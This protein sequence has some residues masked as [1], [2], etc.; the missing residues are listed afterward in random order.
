VTRPLD[1]LGAR[2]RHARKKRQLGQEDLAGAANES[3][4]TISKIERG[5]IQQPTSIARLA[6][7][8]EVWLELGH[9]DEPDWDKSQHTSAGRVA[10][11]VAQYVI[12]SK[13]EDAPHIDLGANM[14]PQSL[15]RVFWTP[16][17]DDA[18]APR[19]LAGKLL[20]FDKGMQPRAGDGI[21]VSDASGRLSVRLYRVAPLGRWTA[22][23]LNPSYEPM[24]SEQH[25]LAVVAVLKAEEGRWA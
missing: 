5:E 13:F 2:L 8:L 23:A 24:D 18:M 19:V 16:M 6:A 17:P 3:Q 25:G 7:A 11:R 10:E 21:L 9:G 4:P 20:C 22:H 12:Q 1:T 14:N 15:P